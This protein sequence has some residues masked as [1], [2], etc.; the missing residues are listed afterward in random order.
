[1]DVHACIHQI[2]RD[3]SQ[4]FSFHTF[5]SMYA[6]M[7]YQAPGDICNCKHRNSPVAGNLR[8]RMPAQ[9]AW[10]RRGHKLT[11]QERE[12]RRGSRLPGSAQTDTEPWW[13]GDL[14]CCVR[15]WARAPAPADASERGW[16][17]RGHT[18]PSGP[19]CWLA[20]PWVGYGLI[21][22]RPNFTMLK[23]WQV[24]AR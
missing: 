4:H 2:R 3:V 23:V 11:N 21:S 10:Q 14:A 8:A 19:H 5:R 20:E 24:K 6:L 9:A 17:G 13:V 18:C 16:S 15:A 12:K 7:T 22:L 1:M